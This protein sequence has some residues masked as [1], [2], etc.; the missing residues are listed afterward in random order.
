MNSG[1]TLFGTALIA[2]VAAAALILRSGGEYEPAESA[3]HQSS[4][5]ARAEL[6]DPQNRSVGTANL[7]STENGVRIEIEVNGLPEGRHGFHIHEVG[8]CDPP[9]FTTAGGHFNPS[10]REH[11][12]ENPNGPHAGDL[13]NIVVRADGTGSLSVVNPYLSLGTGAD[14]DLLR[15]DGTSVMIHAGPDDY[16]T[17]PAG[18]SGARLACGVIVATTR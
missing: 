14:N 15:G 2:V 13:P 1:T 3:S 11:G 17:D 4:T 5:T 12:M 6:R 9:E 10:G 18:D 16:F 7:A 8:R